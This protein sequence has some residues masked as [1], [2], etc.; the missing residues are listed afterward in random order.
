VFRDDWVPR[1]LTSTQVRDFNFVIWGDG[2]CGIR[3]VRR[4][5]WYFGTANS[6]RNFLGLISRFWTQHH[7]FS[8]MA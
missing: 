7:N 5:N 6:F 4:E 1:R 3:D 2:D 8:V